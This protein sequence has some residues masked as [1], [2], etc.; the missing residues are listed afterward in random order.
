[1]G[2]PGRGRCS[3]IRSPG[4]CTARRRLRRPRRARQ[5][6]HACSRIGIRRGWPSAAGSRG[7]CASAVVTT[8]AAPLAP[9]GWPIIDLVDEPGK[10]IG[11]RAEHAAHAARF[12]RIVQLRGR[13]VVVDVADLFVR[14]ARAFAA[15]RRCSATISSPSGIHLHAVIGV[16]RRVVAVDRRVDR[17]RRAR[18]RDPRARARSIH[19]PSPSTKPSRPRSNGR[20]ACR[21]PIVVARRDRAHAREAEDHPR[22]DA[23]V[24]AAATA[25]R[26]LRRSESARAA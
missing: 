24:G 20:D 3:S 16:A 8:P 4:S 1:M 14:A 23:A 6:V 7:R 21:R 9:C 26:R 15:R 10:P 25:A 22:R 19:A 5:E 13:A 2:E 11:V 12:D 18:A 17:A